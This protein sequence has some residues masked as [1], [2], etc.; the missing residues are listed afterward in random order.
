MTKASAIWRKVSE[1]RVRAFLV[2]SED[3]RQRMRGKRTETEYK[4]DDRLEDA[5][6]ADPVQH[7]FSMIPNKTVRRRQRNRLKAFFGRS[8][9][10]R[11][12]VSG[13]MHR[14]KG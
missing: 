11:N 1:V 12:K 3:Y 6:R 7:G 13:F 4:R 8:I 10:E 5:L 14:Y 9:H 2:S